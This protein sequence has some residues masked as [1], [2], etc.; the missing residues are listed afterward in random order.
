M[1]EGQ[2]AAAGSTTAGMLLRR[3]REQA[4]LHVASLAVNLKVPVRK[5]EALEEDRYD[6]L[7]DAVF[8]RALASSV[9]RTLK[10]DPQPVLERLPQTARPRLVQNNDGINTPFRAPGDGPRP[11]V[12][13]QL[14][15]PV[16]LTVIALL[17]AAVVLVFLPVTREEAAS[18]ASRSEPVMPP[19]TPAAVTAAPA[20]PRVTETVTPAS[21]A[22][23]APATPAPAAATPP[24]T[25][26]VPAPAQ[27]AAPAPAAAVTPPGPA[28]SALTAAS[29]QTPITGS[30]GIVVF[31]TRG[32]S[33]VQVTD[34]K[35]TP[36]F[37]RLMEAGET[38]GATGALPLSVTV[39]SVEA[40]DVQV[41]GKPFNL[42]PVTKDNVARFEVK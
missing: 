27:T 19:G 7:P 9:C 38:A 24:A 23:V 1:N 12:L 32:S 28:D 21:S 6:L 8:V 41:R 26:P 25:T 42:G 16:T 22:A 30:T 37:R 3:A 11:G 4:G 2:E 40:T 31:R 39:G 5:L 18:L 13:D 33:W 36:V 20:E 10:I 34:A 15:R 14:S 17:L 29:G 35:G